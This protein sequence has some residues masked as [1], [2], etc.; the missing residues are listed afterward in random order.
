MFCALSLGCRYRVR[1]DQPIGPLLY[2][3]ICWF[4][5]SYLFVHQDSVGFP[6]LL[7]AWTITEIIRS[8]CL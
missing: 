6:L 1:S 3:S 2:E 4:R 7:F 5:F 8:C